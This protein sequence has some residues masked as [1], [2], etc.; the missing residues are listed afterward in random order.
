MKESI[1]RPLSLMEQLNRNTKAA[2]KA[3]ALIE[4]EELIEGGMGVREAVREVARRTGFGERSLFTYRRNTNYL[5]REDWPSALAHKGFSDRRKAD[6][7]P[8][9]LQRFV[10]LCRSGKSIADSYRVAAAEAEEKGLEP[11]PSERTMRRELDR[12]L[13]PAER[14][15]AKRNAKPKTE[16]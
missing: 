6:C 7:H 2:A 12:L 5:P 10:A 9:V 8:E 15:A 4:I 14:Y 11:V 1:V 16:V 3:R 13:P